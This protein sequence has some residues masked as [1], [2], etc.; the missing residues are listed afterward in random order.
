V[1]KMNK[2]TI[3]N[4][5][6]GSVLKIE[7]DGEYIQVYQYNSD[8]EQTAHQGKKDKIEDVVKNAEK[9]GMIVEVE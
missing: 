2:A 7:K 4:P 8:G 1:N 9:A 3:T 5:K 6:N